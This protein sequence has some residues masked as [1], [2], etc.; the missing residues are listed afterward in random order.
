MYDFIVVG[1]RCAGASLGAFLGRYGYRVL[2]ID[3]FAEPGPTLSNHII[4][5]IDVYERLG[6]REKMESVGAPP[7][8]RVRVDLEGH[9]FESD[10][11]VT[12]RA[13]GIRREYL[14]RFLL[15][16]AVSYPNVSCLFR[17]KVSSVIYDEGKVTGV[18][19]Q[20]ENGESREFY[21]NVVIGADGRNSVIAK[22][23]ET[24]AIRSIKQELHAVYYG[25]LSNVTPLPI[26]TFEWY[27]NDEDIVLCNPIDDGLHCFA[28]MVPNHEALSWKDKVAE[29]FMAR[30]DRIKTLASRVQK[31]RIV[32]QIKGITNFESYVKKAYGNGWVLVGDAGVNL[33]PITGVG[34]DN[35]VCCAEYLAQELHSYMLERKSWTSAMDE[36]VR[37][38]DERIQP[39]YEASLRTLS[40]TRMSLTESDHDSLG[41]LCTF[42]S[43][44]KTLALKS[45]DVLQLLN[46]NE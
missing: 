36:Y 46:K 12:T 45:A 40:Y 14:D 17:T 13:L 15:D 2:L 30:I 19:C 33:H 27:W 31:S 35:A 38:R 7:L 22:N 44:V 21:A 25:Y 3:K 4:G 6:V 37:L 28:V 1:A 39:Q 5:E 24:S 32:G 10:I 18:V 41:L 23:V 42:P 43:L 9:V 11:R 26:P 34:I 29:N 20:M 8:T 16:E